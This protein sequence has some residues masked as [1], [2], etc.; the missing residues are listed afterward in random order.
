MIC[1]EF[2]GKR[3]IAVASENN[4][5]Y[6]LMNNSMYLIEK[7]KIDKCVLKDET[8]CDFLFLV[9]SN[10]KIK[11][12]FWIELKGSNVEQA[13]FQILQTISKVETENELIH[14]ARIV[15]SKNPNPRLRGTDYRKLETFVRNQGGTIKNQNKLLEETI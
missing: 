1:R 10:E 12:A 15:P 3:K 8:A 14:H 4:K 13:A 6:R 5:A 7:W 11:D 9:N 2:S